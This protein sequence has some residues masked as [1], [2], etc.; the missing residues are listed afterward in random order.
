MKS[1]CRPDGK[2]WCQ[3]CCTGTRK[4]CPLR[5][6]TGGGKMGC[7]GHGGKAVKGL[8]QISFC[9]EFDCLARIGADKRKKIAVLVS[10]LTPGEFRMSEVLKAVR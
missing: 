3:E 9:Q 2:R 8:T 1:L 5:G 6:D 10:Q 7:L 4:N